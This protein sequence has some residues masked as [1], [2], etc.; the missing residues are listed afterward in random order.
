MMKRNAIFLGVALM[1][2]SAAQAEFRVDDEAPAAPRQQQAARQAPAVAQPIAGTEVQILGAAPVA[3]KAHVTQVGAPTGLIDIS[4]GFGRGVTFQDAMKQIVPQGWKGYAIGKF[5]ASKRVD[6]KGGK[7]PWIAVLEEVAQEAG[8]MAQVDWTKHEINFYSIEVE[9]APEAAKPEAKSEAAE[10]APAPAAPRDAWE[11]KAGL[12]LH[13]NLAQWAKEA[14]WGF[15]WRPDF[16]YVIANVGGK[17]P[18]F[19]G[20]F[21]EA[22]TQVVGAYRNAERPLV[23]EFFEG[24]NVLEVREAPNR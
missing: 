7:R 20:T 6:W 11:L 16:K 13:D 18:V 17:N 10:P 12:A 9:K 23:A 5:D 15:V 22:V 4:L 8:V 3:R 2:A 14:G 21:I 24:N 1:A 19:K